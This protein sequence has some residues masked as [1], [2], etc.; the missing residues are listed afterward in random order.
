MATL[1]TAL[2]SRR[3]R[4]VSRTWLIALIS[5]A[6]LGDPL[7]DAA[8]VGLQLGLT[9][10]AQT[11][12]AVRATGPATGL[13][14]QRRAPAAQ[15]REEVVELGELDLRLALLGPGVL[16]ED[17]QDQRGAVDHLDLEP[18][19][20]VAQLAGRELA[21][22]DDGVGAGGHDDVGELAAPCRSRCR[23]PGPGW[24]RRWTSASSTAEP[25]VSASRAS[26]ASEASASAAVPSVHTPTST[27]RSRWSCRYST[28]VMSVE[29][30][31]QP[32]TRRSAARSASSSSPVDTS[33][34]SAV[35]VRIE[36]VGF[37]HL[38]IY[39]P[40]CCPLRYRLIRRGSWPGRSRPARRPGRLGQVDVVGEHRV[41][42]GQQLR[43][44]LGRQLV[45][46]PGEVG[47]GH[48]EVGDLAEEGAPAPPR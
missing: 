19:L 39:S 2:A 15:P 28:S 32:P 18:L 34:S 23:S 9:G 41:Q 47:R 4:L 27:T 14:G 29:F 40:T 26:S 24:S 16:G 38:D 6:Q 46:H 1:G 5:P 37:R 35:V 31:G 8:A 25:A 43:G 42:P 30:G 13:P 11:H 10:T 21:V 36:C 33:S 12:A 45:D 3:P 48:A 22:A 17:V 20:Q 7:V 44:L